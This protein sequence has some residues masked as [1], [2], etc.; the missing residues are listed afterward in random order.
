MTTRSAPAWSS[1]GTAASERRPG[2]DEQVAAH[3]TARQ[4][5]V[6]VLGVAVESGDEHTGPLDARR[7]QDILV[8]GVPAHRGAVHGGDPHG[9]RVDDHDLGVA[10]AQGAGDGPADPPPAA[11]HDVAVHPADLPLHPAPPELISEVALDEHL[12]QH[13]EGIG[14]GP[15]PGQDED[16]SEH[17]L[18]RAELMH[19]AEA[20]GGHRDHRLEDGVEYAVAKGHVADGAAHQDQEQADEPQPEVSRGPVPSG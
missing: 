10:G 1:L 19:L 16:D 13:A 12:D 15:H 14:R 3:R 4:G 11:H 2:D 7:P 8:R 9:R 17:L 5:H 20:D 6:Q 18:A